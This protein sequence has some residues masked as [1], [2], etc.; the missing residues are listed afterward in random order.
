MRFRTGSRWV[1]H[2]RVVARQIRSPH[3]F[4]L[5]RLSNE[6]AAI[7]SGEGFDASRITA[8]ALIVAGEI[9]PALAP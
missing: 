2:G 9:G 3:G 8:A 1:V 5:W 7:L 6:P 4:A